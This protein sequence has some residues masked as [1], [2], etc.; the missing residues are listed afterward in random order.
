MY[1]GSVKATADNL[2]E[3]FGFQPYCSMGLET[4][5]RKLCSIVV[6]NGNVIIQVMNT[7]EPLHSD[8]DDPLI[9]E[10]HSHIAFHG[11]SVKD[12]AFKVDNV[13][14]AFRKAL[15]A[16]GRIVMEP[17]TFKDE[18]GEITLAKIAGIDDTVHTLVDRSKYHGFLPGPYRMEEFEESAPHR[19]ENIIMNSVD[20]VVQNDG[21]NKMAVDCEYYERVF[22]FHQFWSVDER[23]ISTKYS[24]LRSTVMASENEIIKMPVNEPAKGLKTSQI[25]EFM[26]FNGT[27]G[28]Q[29]VAIRVDDILTTVDHLKKRGVEFIEVPDK[30]Y[31]NLSK[32][33][34]VSG[35]P[36]F[37][38]SLELI[39]SLG[40]LVD[41]DEKG[42]LL[43]LFTRP[44]FDRPTFFFE[45]IQRH[46]HNGFGAGN[47][48]GLFEVLELDQAKRG[49]LKD[50]A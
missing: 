8:P 43:Q 25:E 23:Q 38:E 3:K 44:L 9:D 16:G 29:H 5:S 4:G 40:I 32:R 22:G 41:F 28:I 34:E 42:Y 31:Q 30:Y 10:I 49:N 15:D 24:A 45:I 47:F 50:S 39:K 11:D 36:E 48:K 6:K 33:M 27:S 13:E 14:A 2:V 20:H 1:V 46:N 21:W 17:E 7:L 18:F 26:D 35:H 12:V 19:G 37:A